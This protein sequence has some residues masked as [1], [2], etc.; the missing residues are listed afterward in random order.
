MIVL[1][2]DDEPVSR[3]VLKRLLSRFSELDPREADNGQTAWTMLGEIIPELILCDLSMPCM[4]GVTFI[5]QLREHPVFGSIPVIVTSAST[6]RDTLLDLKDR[7]L[8]DYLL[9]PFDL[10]RTFHRL[11]RSINPLLARYRQRK[12]EEAARAAL[13]AV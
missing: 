5:K 8:L 4:D 9:K 1:I 10:V 2:V 7:S 11:E 3:R 13:K 12:K 6:D